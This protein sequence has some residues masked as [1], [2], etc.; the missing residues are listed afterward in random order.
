MTLKKTPKQRDVKIEELIN[1]LSYFLVLL[2]SAANNYVHRN[3]Y[4][5]HLSIEVKTYCYIVHFDPDEI[6]VNTDLV[7]VS[8]Q[9]S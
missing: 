6:G 5:I 7:S 4:A 3:V 9:E 2:T 8:K 1:R